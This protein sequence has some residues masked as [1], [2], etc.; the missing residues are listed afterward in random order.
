MHEGV[1]IKGSVIGDMVLNGFGF[2][3][4][5]GNE[6]ES[7]DG[8]KRELGAGERVEKVEIKGGGVAGDGDKPAIGRADEET[9]AD[10]GGRDGG[11]VRGGFG[12]WEELEGAGSAAGE[13][14]PGR[15]WS[16]RR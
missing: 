10:E 8:R 16:R 15:G 1:M 5:R 6:R 12:L 7:V 4:D 9:A 3:R 13:D 2:V 14:E 11:F